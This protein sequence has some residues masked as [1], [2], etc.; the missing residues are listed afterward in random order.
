MNTDLPQ[1]IA[2]TV[3][4]HSKPVLSVSLIGFEQ[5]SEKL[6]YSTAVSLRAW[7]NH[8]QMRTNDV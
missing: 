5:L 3:K 2:G 6:E 1:K 7:R 4:L 8:E